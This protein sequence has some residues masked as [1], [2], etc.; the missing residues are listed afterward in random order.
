[1]HPA[2]LHDGLRKRAFRCTAPRACKVR[3]AQVLKDDCVTFWTKHE[4][5]TTLHYVRIIMQRASDLEDLLFVK[6]SAELA[7]AEYGVDPNNSADADAGAVGTPERSEARQAPK[8]TP[9]K[10][11]HKRK[12]K[13][14]TPPTNKKKASPKKQR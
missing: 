6:S 8:R 7:A 9:E 4:V 11:S 12:P 13:S 5:Q 2:S 3:I 10:A 14:V 1:M